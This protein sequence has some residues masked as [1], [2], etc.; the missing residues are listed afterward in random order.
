MPIAITYT[1]LAGAAI[2]A[3][4]AIVLVKKKSAEIKKLKAEMEMLEKE[5]TAKLDSFADLEQNFEQKIDEVIQSSIQKISH[6]EEAKDEAVKAAQDN[7]EAAAEAHAQIKE[8]E[9][10]IKDLEA[11]LG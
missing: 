10:K 6:A 11:K 3:V 9:K 2:I 8:G 7:Y 4:F 1:A 5:S